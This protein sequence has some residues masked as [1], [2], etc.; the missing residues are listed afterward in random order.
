MTTRSWLPNKGRSLKIYWK[1]QVMRICGSCF[2][3]W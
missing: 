2:F 1:P 3:K